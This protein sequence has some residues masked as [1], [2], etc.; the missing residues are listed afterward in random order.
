MGFGLKAVAKSL[1][2]LG[3]IETNWKDGIVDGLGAM[4][5]AWW[6]NAEAKS[7]NTRMES[8]PL[9]QDVIEYNQIDCKVMMETLYHIRMH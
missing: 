4:A 2:A 5:A 3:L 8:L 1:H 6:A 7:Q 9:I